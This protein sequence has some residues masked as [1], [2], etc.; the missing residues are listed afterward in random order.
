VN[1]GAPGYVPPD[2][3][4]SGIDPVTVDGDVSIANA[5]PSPTSPS[6]DV[7][8][9]NDFWG[10]GAPIRST[11]PGGTTDVYIPAGSNVTFT[12]TSFLATDPEP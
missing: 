6:I 8:A 12:S 9:S 1:N 5:V 4:P 10:G 7:Y 2:A 11:T 3:D